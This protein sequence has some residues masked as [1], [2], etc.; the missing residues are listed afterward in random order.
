MYQCT[1]LTCCSNR[2]FQKCNITYHLSTIFRNG[3]KVCRKISRTT[4]PSH[5]LVPCSLALFKNN[6][7]SPF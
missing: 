3:K 5:T 6:H 4:G 1:N 7:K 2:D